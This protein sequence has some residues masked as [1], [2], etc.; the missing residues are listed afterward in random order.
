MKTLVATLFILIAVAS[1]SLAQW[2][3]YITAG[4]DVTTFTGKEKKEWGGTDS[5]PKWVI[6]GHAGIL[7]ERILSDEWEAGA[8][9]Q[10]AIKGT[11]YAGDVEYYDVSS[12]SLEMINV[13]YTKLLTYIDLPVYVKY[14]ASEKW[15]LIGGLQPSLLLSAKVKNDE[16]ARQAY[17]GLPATED[18]RDYYTTLDIAV[19]IGPRYQIS[20]KLSLEL[21]VKPGIL[22][23]AKADSYDGAGSMGER[24]Y[25]VHNMGVGISVVYLIREKE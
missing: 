5:N 22:K 8:G 14:L 3:F 21:L 10:F 24:R 1:E 13:K 16:N 18:A 19:L 25:K 2:R 12:G 9:L 17:P 20:D 7:V 11:A 23:I 4:P 6:R 15:H